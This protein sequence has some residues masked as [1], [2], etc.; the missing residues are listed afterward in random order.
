MSHLTVTVGITP[1][2]VSIANANAAEPECHQIQIRA[3]TAHLSL[4]GE[5]EGIEQVRSLRESLAKA[6]YLLDDRIALLRSLEA[7][8]SL[9]DA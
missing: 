6:V 4:F 9:A 5:G 7:T 3:G 2:D 1:N 8:S